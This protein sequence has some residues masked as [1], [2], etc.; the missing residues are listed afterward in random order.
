MTS[1]TTLI[2]L[3]FILA[4]TI[5]WI[6][7]AN[8]NE[9]V[10]TA[11]EKINSLNR[12]RH[13]VPLNIEAL[14]TI[15]EPTKVDSII[16]KK[17]DDDVSMKLG[18]G[19]VLRKEAGDGKLDPPGSKYAYVTLIH[20]IDDSF[21]YRGYLYN[22]MIMKTA[23]ASFGST[24]DFIVLLGFTTNGNTDKFQDDIDKLRE[25][26]IRIYFLPRLVDTPKV[27]FGEMALLKV[28]PWSF[29]QYEK[30]Q[31]FDGDIMPRSNMDCYF[32]LEQNTFNVGNASPLNSGWYMAIPNMQDFETLR[33]KAITR[34]TQK[35]DEVIGWG[36]VPPPWLKNARGKNI[37]AK[38]TFNGASLDQG[39]LT[40][41]F[42][43]NNGRIMLLNE[44]QAMKYSGHGEDGMPAINSLKCC[45]GK[46]PVSQFSHFTGKSKPWLNDLRNAKGGSPLAMWARFLDGLNLPGVNSST[47]QEQGLK[48]P[49][50]YF[51]PNT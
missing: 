36:E 41:Y 3:S 39:L 46:T 42:M 49:L 10:S 19:Q 34:L 47:I 16:K 18:P 45:Q 14:S 23:L 6:S 37:F 51:H 26:G 8:E 13:I 15:S 48:P 21:K 24:A 28:T 1:I 22:V 9:F 4:V 27:H 33:S 29:T 31:F 20:G 38:W 44:Q 32:E 11:T 30:I 17:D 25:I 50:G 2:G 43:I 35:W 12:H 5:L 40:H 7:F